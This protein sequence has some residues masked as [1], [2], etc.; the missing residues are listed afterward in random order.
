MTM[1]KLEQELD[2]AVQ[3]PG[4]T[5]LFVP[6]IR[7]RIDMLAT[8]IKS[9]IGIKISGPDIDVLARLGA[10]IEEV[11]VDVPGVSSAI[12]ERTTGGRY[13]DVEVQPAV[14][15]RYGLTQADV[16]PLIDTVVGGQPVAQHPDKRRVGHEGG[17][18]C[19][20]RLATVHE[21]K[22]DT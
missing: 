5:N 16:Q 1:E 19:R 11:A 14:A 4:L 22:T 3:V 15:A 21:K 10:G 17:S 8:G 9:P 18:T 6:P 7:N 13:L 12:A 2:A 20:S